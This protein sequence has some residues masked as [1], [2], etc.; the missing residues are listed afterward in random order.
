M[1]I[2][3]LTNPKHLELKFKLFILFST[4]SRKEESTYNASL[5]IFLKPL[6]LQFGIADRFPI[7]WKVGKSMNNL[8]VNSQVI[9]YGESNDIQNF[10]KHVSHFQI[11]QNTKTCTKIFIFLFQKKA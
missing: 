11:I 2:F 5:E 9:W 10:L 6:I 8:S 4:L 3:R 1:N 7:T